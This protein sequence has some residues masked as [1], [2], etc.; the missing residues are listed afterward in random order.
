MDGGA[1]P[2]RS[3]NTADMYPVDIGVGSESEVLKC[4]QQKL[5]QFTFTMI[6][7]KTNHD[8]TVGHGFHTL[9]IIKRLKAISDGR[10]WDKILSPGGVFSYLCPY[11]GKTLRTPETNIKSYSRTEN[12]LILPTGTFS[13]ITFGYAAFK[14]FL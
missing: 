10:P 5:E 7:S 11:C 1:K 2:D 14:P 8:V 6:P 3:N 4:S 12:I 9:C 13:T